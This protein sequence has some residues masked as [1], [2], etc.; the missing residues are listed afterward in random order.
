[1]I[2]IVEVPH[3]LTAFCWAAADKADAVDRIAKTVLFD[4]PI[5]EAS[6]ED[7]MAVNSLDLRQQFVFM[8]AADANAALATTAF[9]TPEA[10]AAL[11]RMLA[12]YGEL[13]DPDPELVEEVLA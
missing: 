4:A 11:Q 3:R 1:M 12:F 2:Y 10:R 8:T 7:W 9:P 5:A 6:F 13:G